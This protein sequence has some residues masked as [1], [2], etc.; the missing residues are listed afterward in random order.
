MEVHAAADIFPLMSDADLAALVEDIRE[1]GQR[2]PIIVHGHLI[3][4]GRNRHRACLQLGIKPKLKEWDEV[5]TAAAYVISANLRRRHLNESQRAMI[6]TRLATLERGQKKADAQI[7]ASS[8][9][10]A[11]DMLK[12]SRRSVQLAAVVQDKAAPELVSAVERGDIPVST[13]AKLVELPA[14]RQREIASAG[15][16]AAAKS[17]KQIDQRQQA[18]RVA[19]APSAPK[20]TEHDKD[21]RFLRQT[22]AATCESARVAFATEQGFRLKAVA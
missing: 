19:V 12:V 22:W 1:N 15:K 14:S 18:R 13:A 16:K 7:C 2:E 17:A 20:E 3:L 5:G 11:A 8:Q 4:D 6:A 9:N 21:L 10:D